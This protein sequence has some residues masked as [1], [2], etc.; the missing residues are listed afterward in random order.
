MVEDIVW[1]EAGLNA[2]Q[3]GVIVFVIKIRPVLEIGVAVVDVASILY[4]IGDGF[5]ARIRIHVLVK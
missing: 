3:L 1:I 4:V 5:T 2:L